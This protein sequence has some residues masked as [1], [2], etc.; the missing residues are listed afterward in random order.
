MLA[1]ELGEAAAE[2]GLCSLPGSSPDV[3]VVGYTLGGGLSWLGAA[4]RLRLQPGRGDR[5]RDR[6]R[7]GA[8]GRR[9]Q[10]RRTSS[11]RFAA[12]AGATRSSPRMHVDLLPIAEV[13]GGALVY[14]AEVGP[15]A[16]RAYRDWTADGR[17]GGDLDRPLPA[18]AAAPRR[19]RA[20]ARQAAAD[21]R[22]RL[23][24]R[25]G[26]GRAADRPAA[27]ARRADH[28]HVRPDAGRRAE[29]DPHGSRA[30][31]SRA[32]PS[33]ADPRAPRRGDRGLL[34]RRRPAGRLAAAARR[35]PPR[36]RR[37]RRGRPRTAGRSTISTRSS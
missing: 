12:A 17:R 25:P 2:H 29:Q 33:R 31:G 8:H 27:R 26:R 5:G 23:H 10:R 7:R 36:R 13:Y 15:T 34:R 21:D 3:G 1:L 19:P 11:G 30:A 24:R 20:A 32:R 6:R 4:L 35:A 28:G 18:P 14:P 16:V 37:A 22:R 9:R